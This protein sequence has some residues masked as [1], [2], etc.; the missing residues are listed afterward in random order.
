MRKKYREA[1][2]SHKRRIGDLEYSVTHIR[3]R[4]ERE[5]KQ[6]EIKLYLKGL[7]KG[8]RAEYE[9]LTTAEI[10]PD[11]P[12]W[13]VRYAYSHEQAVTIIKEC[14]GGTNQT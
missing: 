6:A 2:L 1:L 4:H 3:L 7:T 5:D 9:R 13:V 11:N 12:R 14:C 8:Q 10:D